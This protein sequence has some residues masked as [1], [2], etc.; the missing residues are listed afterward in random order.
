ML[1]PAHVED[2][3]S[4]GRPAPTRHLALR[5]DAG[6]ASATTRSGA[7]IGDARRGLVAPVRWGGSPRTATTTRVVEE[8]KE[9][10]P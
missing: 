9:E 7:S 1:H 6:P 4:I 3:T 5:E 8:P 2:V 10:P